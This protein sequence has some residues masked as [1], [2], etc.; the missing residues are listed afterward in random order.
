MCPRKMV[1]NCKGLLFFNLCK[2]VVFL[3]ENIICFGK[4][5]SPLFPN[6]GIRMDFNKNF[7]GK[8]YNAGLLTMGYE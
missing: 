3:L 7:F 5:E 2:P 1:C 6:C 4:R 8:H